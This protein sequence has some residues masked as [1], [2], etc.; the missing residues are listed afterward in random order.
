VLPNNFFYLNLLNTLFFKKSIFFSY[1]KQYFFFNYQIFKN[2]FLF[3][4]FFNGN[5]SSL[6]KFAHF[7]YLFINNLKFFLCSFT[8][9]IKRTFGEGFAYIKGLSLIF[10]IDASVTDDEP[11]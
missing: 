10:L 3:F 8:A 5:V 1:K 9:N 6:L 7:F 4:S 11:L 2:D